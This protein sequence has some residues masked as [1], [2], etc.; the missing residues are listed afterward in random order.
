MAT[1][2][3]SRQVE[4]ACAA[5]QHRQGV[6][7]HLLRR[8]RELAQLRR[9]LVGGEIVDVAVDGAGQRWRGVRRRVERSAAVTMD[10]TESLEKRV[11]F[12]VRDGQQLTPRPD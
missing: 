10:A 2:S 5:L 4:T 12:L 7:R 6:T 11:L 1:S 9:D 3:M 8:A